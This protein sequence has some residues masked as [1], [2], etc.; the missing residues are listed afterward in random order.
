YSDA[1]TLLDEILQRSDD[2]FFKPQPEKPLYRSLKAE[3]QQLIG[4]MPAEGRQAYEL[5]FGARAQQML[6]V[7]ADSGDINKLEEI[8]RRYF[9]TQAGYQATLLL[10]RHYLDH[11]RPLAAAL[12][13]QRLLDAPAAAA[14]LEPSLSVLLASSWLSGGMTDRAQ[15]TL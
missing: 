15:E 14:A 8:A 2:F 5:Q 12:C 9:H 10:G 7:A 1:V 13:F 6:V 11:N 4:K 3:A